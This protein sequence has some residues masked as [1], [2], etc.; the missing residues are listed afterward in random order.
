MPASF[1]HSPNGFSGIK[2]I[3]KAALSDGKPKETKESGTPDRIL[4]GG[5]GG[6]GGGSCVGGGEQ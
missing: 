2:I 5:G 3:M 4:K 6:G 1:L